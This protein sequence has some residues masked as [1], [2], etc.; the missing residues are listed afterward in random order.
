MSKEPKIEK[1]KSKISFGIKF[2]LQFENKSI[3]GS[4]WAKLLKNIEKNKEGSLT[5]AA[6]ECNYSYKYA[7]NI[8]KRIEKRT[9]MPV[10]ITGKGGTGGGG[11]IKLNEWGHYLLDTYNQYF[12]EISKIEQNLEGTVKTD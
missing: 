11:W 3:L 6:K 1:L 9:G 10:V 7:W 2:W 5:Q 8:L 12:K 4:G